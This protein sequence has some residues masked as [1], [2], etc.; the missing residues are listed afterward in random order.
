MKKA[1]QVDFDAGWGKA[2]AKQAGE[3]LREGVD[4]A[5]P[6]CIQQSAKL[7]N[8]IVRTTEAGVRMEAGDGGRRVTEILGEY[9]QLSSWRRHHVLPAPR[10]ASLP[11]MVGEHGVPVNLPREHSIPVNL[12]PHLLNQSKISNFGLERRECSSGEAERQPR[13]KVGFWVLVERR[14]YIYLTS[15][16][17][18]APGEEDRSAC[19]RRRAAALAVG[20]T[21]RRRLATCRLLWCSPRAAAALCE[22]ESREQ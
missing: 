12:R 18:A 11:L 5:R 15:G 20:S 13:R 22:A 14:G 6:T 17:T 7:L 10:A 4:G 2:Y 21:A 16:G 9:L 3:G 8:F 1:G 19:G